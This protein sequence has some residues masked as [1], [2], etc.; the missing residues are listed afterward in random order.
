MVTEGGGGGGGG[1][2]H[3]NV[4]KF[5]PK[6]SYCILYLVGWRSGISTRFPLHEAIPV[7]G[8]Q[9]RPPRCDWYSSWNLISEVTVINIFQSWP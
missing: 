6:F 8:R 3:D 2:G 9:Y 1:F 5:S 4:I 7:R